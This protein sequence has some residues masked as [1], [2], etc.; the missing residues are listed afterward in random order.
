MDRLILFT[1]HTGNEE[2]DD[3]F[4]FAEKSAIGV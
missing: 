1:T 4:E 2:P 3:E